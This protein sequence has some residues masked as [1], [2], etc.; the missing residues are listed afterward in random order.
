MMVLTSLHHGYGAIIYQSHFRLHVL[1]VSIPVIIL[2]AAL[3]YAM[4]RATAGRWL[5][6]A[7]LGLVTLIP[8]AGIGLFEGLYNH[9]VKNLLYFLG[10]PIPVFDRLF[11][12]P[13][14]EKPN[15][16]IFELTG[17]LQALL[18]LPLAGAMTGLFKARRNHD[19]PV[20]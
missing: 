8:L 3:Y 14:Y 9:A 17:I 10:L 13:T 11:P 20:S 19:Q 12:P 1:L 18:V 15:N 6:W 2:L 16:V 4:I 5:W 7:Y